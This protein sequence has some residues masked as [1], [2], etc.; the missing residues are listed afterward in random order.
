MKIE[1]EIEM[2]QVRKKKIKKSSSLSILLRFDPNLL[3]LL[4]N[5]RIID[6]DEEH[7]FCKKRGCTFNAVAPIQE[8]I[9]N[10]S[11]SQGFGD[12]NENNG[13]IRGDS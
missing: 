13:E 10:L 9:C 11:H 7:A 1:T 3:L 8:H 6:R 12:E 5:V 4:Y 2:D